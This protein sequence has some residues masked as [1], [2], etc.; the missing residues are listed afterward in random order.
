[1]IAVKT[2]LFKL[3]QIL[4]HR[5]PL[6]VGASRPNAMG[7]RRSSCL[8][9]IGALS[10]PKTQKHNEALKDGSRLAF[11]LHPERRQTKLWV[12]TEAED[13]GDSCGDNFASAIRVLNAP[14]SPRKP[15]RN[16][17]CDAKLWVRAGDGD[18]Y[19]AS[20]ASK[21]SPRYLSEMGAPGLLIAATIRRHF[22]GV[23]RPEL[24]QPLLGR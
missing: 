12:I 6:R 19:N 17:P 11:G 23:S 10:V 5:V 14:L 4:S 18:N 13:E 21:R 22:A 15:K 24:H 7:V 2:P 1:M 9:V 8:R 3:G 20:M 16:E